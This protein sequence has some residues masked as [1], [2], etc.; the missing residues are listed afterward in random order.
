MPNYGD[1]F[2]INGRI[3]DEVIDHSRETPGPRHNRG[4]IIAR[5]GARLAFWK[6]RRAFFTRAHRPLSK[7]LLGQFRLIRHDVSV[8]KIGNR[9]AAVDTLF[10]R[11]YFSFCATAT[12]AGAVWRS[13]GIL[14]SHP[15]FR[16]LH[17]GIRD[18][19]VSAVQ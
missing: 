3:A 15:A 6:G 13:A 18:H 7:T 5:F 11:P 2:G 8:V 12:L 4:G 1:A 16:Q 17:L 9:I 14:L 10:D 19:G